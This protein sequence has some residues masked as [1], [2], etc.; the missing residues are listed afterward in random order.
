MALRCDISTEGTRR[1]EELAALIGPS[2]SPAWKE[3]E[4]GMGATILKVLA[5]IAGIFLSIAAAASLEPV[6]GMVAV[7]L[8]LLT[9]ATII[10]NAGKI[11]SCFAKI[12][13]HFQRQYNRSHYGTRTTTRVKVR[14]TRRTGGGH[15]PHRNSRNPSPS[16]FATPRP[17]RRP[18][19]AQERANQRARRIPTHISDASS[20]S[21]SSADLH[22]RPAPARGGSSVRFP[23]MM[24][25]MDG[26]D[27]LPEVRDSMM[28]SGH[29]QWGSGSAA[30]P[31]AGSS[32]VTRGGNVGW[33]AGSAPAAAPPAYTVTAAGNVGFGSG[34]APA[35]ASS[36]VVNDAGNVGFGSG[37]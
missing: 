12:S 36:F 16:P 2:H 10:G 29:A 25:S 22:R 20:S 31:Q 35:P 26:S 21:S 6:A 3:G 32:T 28:G 14:T 24:R 17:A 23:N 13:I 27:F 15:P 37:L 7:G 11:A 9:V 8:I 5:I 19:T 1:A 4:G 18:T 33:G 30:A 34:Q